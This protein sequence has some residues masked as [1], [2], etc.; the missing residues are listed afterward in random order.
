MNR[1]RTCH[2]HLDWHHNIRISTCTMGTL[3]IQAHNQISHNQIQQLEFLEV[4]SYIG[5]S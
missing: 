5:N 4:Q 2:T 3:T 1:H